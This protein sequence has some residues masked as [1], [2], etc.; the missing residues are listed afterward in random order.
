MLG[1]DARRT[2]VI[3]ILIPTPRCDAAGRPKNL[4]GVHSK[5][6]RKGLSGAADLGQVYD[7]RALRLIVG[8][9]QDCYAALREVER[10]WPSVPGRFKVQ[11]F[12]PRLYPSVVFQPRPKTQKA[13]V[14]RLNVGGK[15]GCYAALREVERLWSAV[16]GRFKM[17]QQ[18]MYGSKSK[19]AN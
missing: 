1:T 17:W 12:R 5:L 2:Q 3:I 13:G 7:V 14:P 4:Y 9:K 10:L 18:N 11:I 15:Q 16:P 6:A 19:P 8:S